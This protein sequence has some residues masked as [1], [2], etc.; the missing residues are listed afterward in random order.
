MIVAAVSNAHFH[1]GSL[2]SWPSFRFPIS[3]HKKLPENRPQTTSPLP[4]VAEYKIRPRENPPKWSREGNEN[5]QIEMIMA[6]V[7]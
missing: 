1:I 7:F 3:P 2:G 5:F 4:T 6:N